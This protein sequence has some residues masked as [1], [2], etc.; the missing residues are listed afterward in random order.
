[1]AGK[2]HGYHLTKE[3]ISGE[4]TGLGGEVHGIREG[5]REYGSSEGTP[6]EGKDSTKLLDS[7]R[8]CR[9]EKLNS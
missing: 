1:M 7:T 5:T 9:T 2:P 8:S 6:Q 4:G 3:G